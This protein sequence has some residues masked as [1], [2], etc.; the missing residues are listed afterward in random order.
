MIS[1]THTHTHTQRTSSSS[2]LTHTAE[3][4]EHKEQR[5]RSV[6][7]S[8]RPAA[9]D[10]QNEELKGSECS[11]GGKSQRAAFPSI[12]LLWMFHNQGV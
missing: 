5:R 4:D 8:V 9:S 12:Q 3:C 10:E 6:H 2:V 7:V 11:W 1:N